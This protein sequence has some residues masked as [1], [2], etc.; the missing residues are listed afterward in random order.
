V[1]C[2]SAG[3]IA[4]FFAANGSID[5]GMIV[6]RSRGTNAGANRSTENTNPSLASRYGCRNDH[7]CSLYSFGVSTPT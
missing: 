5:G 1:H 4:S 3:R 7:A 2:T 6:R